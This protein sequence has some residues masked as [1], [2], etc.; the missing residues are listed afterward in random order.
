MKTASLHRK[1]GV[2]QNSAKEDFNNTYFYFI[3]NNE[4]NVYNLHKFY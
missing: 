4:E 1:I 3:E 2:E